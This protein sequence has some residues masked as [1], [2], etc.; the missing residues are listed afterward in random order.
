GRGDSRAI[1]KHSCE[2]APQRAARHIQTGAFASGH[3]AQPRHSE[4]GAASAAPLKQ[5]PIPASGA[6]RRCA[7]KNKKLSRYKESSHSLH[8]G[9]AASSPPATP[10]PST[11]ESSCSSSHPRAAES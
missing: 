11:A 2:T 6:A 4:L 9:Y 1:K 8:R 5:K 7:H 3:A 10:P